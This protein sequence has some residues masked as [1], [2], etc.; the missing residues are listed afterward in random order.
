[1][2][3]F[4]KIAP[5]LTNP[6]VLVGF[7]VGLFYGLLRLLLKA[8]VIPPLTRNKGGQIVSS[9]LRYGFVVAVLVIVLG[10]GIEAYRTFLSTQ[11]KLSELSRQ[12]ATYYGHIFVNPGSVAEGLSQSDKGFDWK[13]QYLTM[14][15]LVSEAHLLTEDISLRNRLAARYTQYEELSGLYESVRSDLA[16]LS[17]P[18][19]KSLDKVRALERLAR[20]ARGYKTLADFVVEHQQLYTNASSLARAGNVVK[21]AEQLRAISSELRARHLDQTGG[22]FSHLGV[23]A[24]GYDDKAE[25]LGNFYRGLT[26]DRDHIPLYEGLGYSLWAL[27]ND[28]PN[29]LSFIETG[30]KLTQPLKA[31]VTSSC[32]HGYDDLKGLTTEDREHEQFYR[33]RESRMMAL[34]TS[35][36]E[37]TERYVK[38]FLESFKSLYA[39]F[40]A[41]VQKNEGEARAYA[42]ELHDEEPEDLDYAETATFVALRFARNQEEL[43]RAAQCLRTIAHL[44]A[45]PISIRIA[46][47]DYDWAVRTITDDLHLSES[48]ISQTDST[49]VAGCGAGQSTDLRKVDANN[50]HGDAR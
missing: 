16:A 25:A 34:C 15:S 13:Y 31:A 39:Y 6:L 41:I 48:I 47:V 27:N 29:A 22:Y 26:I 10:F 5:F 23:L 40:S 19:Q 24:L 42:N 1:M 2:P 9:F 8:K 43:I 32:Q 18:D 11:V 46:T 4:E 30:L 33:M 21:A 37:A 3:P 20:Q 14:L 50:A 28:V 49:S 7:V 45:D 12:H 35:L 44:Q 17:Q 36:T 38:Y